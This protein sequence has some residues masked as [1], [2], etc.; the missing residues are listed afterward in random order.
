MISDSGWTIKK[1]IGVVDV[2]TIVSAAYLSPYGHPHRE[3]VER[4]R[5]LGIP[6]RSTWEETG[7]VVIE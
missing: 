2:L 5:T 7:G 4:V 3:V 6:M 1:E